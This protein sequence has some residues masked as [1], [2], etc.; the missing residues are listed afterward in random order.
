[1]VPG[2]SSHARPID[3]VLCD[4]DGTLVVDVPYNRDPALV[5]PMPTVRR[6]LQRLRATGVATGIVSNQSGVARGLLTEDDVE[7][8]NQ[9]VERLLGPFDVTLWCRH[10][11]EDGCRCRKPAPGMVEEAAALLGVDVA[12]C[13]VIGDIGADVGAAQAAGAWGILIPTD[14]TRFE[15][16]AA[17][18]WTAPSFDA[19]VDHVLR[20]PHLTSVTP[21]TAVAVLP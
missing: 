12:R 17:A 16:V 3:A 5:R 20:G 21:L 15:E 19:A 1:M 11:P 18:A 13:A 2:G 9:Q 6:G 14:R 7:R 10:G 8:V 4:R